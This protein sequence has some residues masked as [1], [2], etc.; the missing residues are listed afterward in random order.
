MS[1]GNVRTN[2]ETIA[3]RYQFSWKAQHTLDG[4]KSSFSWIVLMTAALDTHRLETVAERATSR[5]PCGIVT[6]KYGRTG[7]DLNQV[8]YM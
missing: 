1:Y 5:L 7:I 3:S 8:M 2:A 6:L 4:L